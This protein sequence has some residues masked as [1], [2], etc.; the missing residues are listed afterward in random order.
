M[1]FC[2]LQDKSDPPVIK[3]P[4]ETLEHREYLERMGRQG[5]PDSQVGVDSIAT[6]AVTKPASQCFSADVDLWA[7]SLLF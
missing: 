3:V 5:I 7:F 6:V 1:F 2:D 4:E